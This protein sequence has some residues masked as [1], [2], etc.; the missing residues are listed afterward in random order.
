MKGKRLKDK[1]LSSSS[2]SSSSSSLSTRFRS[3]SS[4]ATSTQ[5]IVS[6]ASKL[7]EE[8]NEDYKHKRY[9][10]AI[11]KY[12]KVLDLVDTGVRNRDMIDLSV[13]TLCNRANAYTQLRLYEKALADGERA[14]GLD[15]KSFKAYF[16][17]GAALLGLRR[18]LE[19]QIYFQRSLKLCTEENTR[20]EIK[21]MII[22]ARQRALEHSGAGESTPLLDDV[23]MEVLF[24]ELFDVS[25]NDGCWW[26]QP[27]FTV[28]DVFERRLGAV[29][30]TEDD[31]VDYDTDAALFDV[32][33]DYTGPRLSVPPTFSEVKAMAEYFRTSHKPIHPRYAAEVI[34][35]AWKTLRDAPT[36]VD[37]S[38]PEGGH[39]TVCGDIHGQFYD[40]LHIFEVN[41]WPADNNPYLFNGDLVDRGSFSCEVL[42]T[43]F[44]LR[45]ALP[46]AVFLTRG[47]H[48][49]TNMNILYGFSGEMDAKYHKALDCLALEV[50]CTLPLAHLINKT[51]FVVHGGI[52]AEGAEEQESNEATTTVAVEEE[53]EE[54]EE[55][56]EENNTLNS[57]NSHLR[58]LTLDTIR[59]INRFRQPPEVNDPMSLLL[60]SDPQEALGCVPSRRGVGMW[61]G[62]DVTEAF[63]KENGLSLVVR[64]HEVKMD[65]YEVHHNGSLVTVFSAPN[66]CDKIG[67]LGAF[68]TL[69]APDL[70][71]EFTTFESSPHPIDVHPM[72]YVDKSIKFLTSLLAQ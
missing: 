55:K 2:S 46:G 67:N 45:A 16:R 68:L 60:W 38:V 3:I 14:V 29:Q 52:Y 26:H 25:G 71:P 22:Q 33:A 47:N 65:G 34:L 10:R 41:G 37:I 62:P 32:S 70:K 15:D 18:Y 51:V 58:P 30:R 31:G 24:P 66:Y 44:A 6:K 28:C 40:L 11:E 20:F 59:S 13:V 9:A 17:C 53:E 49:A 57:G 56:E 8:G 72:Q 43:L 1:G 64:S 39:I 12:T 54:K 61:F 27:G 69:R 7:K 48:E 23:L 36:L 19:G 21:K 63:L 35:A 5:A 4:G 42:L 50:F